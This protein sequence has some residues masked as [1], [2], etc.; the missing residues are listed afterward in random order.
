[1]KRT[2]TNLFI[3]NLDNRCGSKCILQK[4]WEQSTG[5]TIVEF[6]KQIMTEKKYKIPNQNISQ[7]FS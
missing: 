6:I 4:W 5:S 1:M 3:L 7:P 2:S